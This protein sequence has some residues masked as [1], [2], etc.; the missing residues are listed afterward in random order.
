ML[1]ALVLFGCITW[2]AGPFIGQPLRCGGI[3]D[4]SRD[5]IALD[6]DYLDGWECGHRIGVLIDHEIYVFYVYDTG[7][8]SDYC[9]YFGSECVPIIGDLP[10]HAYP[11]SGLSVRAMVWN[12]TL[13]KPR[14]DLSHRR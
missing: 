6:L 5:W 11:A 14:L 12:I 4:T 9:V 10:F 8:L 7:P 3:Y 1:R 13:Q 2:Y